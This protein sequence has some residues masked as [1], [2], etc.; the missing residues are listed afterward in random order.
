MSN[1]SSISENLYFEKI[2][3][4]VCNTSENLIKLNFH[5]QDDD[6]FDKIKIDI[7]LPQVSLCQCL[8]CSHHFANP[9]L[10]NIILDKYY[11]LHNSTL[12]N[13]DRISNAEKYVLR[14]QK[15]VKK[16]ETL[17]KG[18]KI[19]EIGC[20][21]GHLLARFD[22]QKWDCHGVEPSFIAANFA[23]ENSG[24]EIVNDFLN[25]KTY[26]IKFDVV[27]L[28]DVLEHLKNPIELMRLIYNYLE[29]NGIVVLSTGDIDSCAYQVSKYYWSYFGSWEHISFFSEKSILHLLN[30][31]RFKN[32]DISH[33]SLVNSF[34]KTGIKNLLISIIGLCF[35]K[36]TFML[37]ILPRKNKNK[38]IYYTFGKDHLI[39][40]GSK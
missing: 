35:N 8:K 14:N 10:T 36:S 15:I 23:K 11:S 7:N 4:P 3:C 17:K 26:K 32:L 28:I 18:G 34:S 40:I 33:V 22:K 31:S 13:I 1:L 29:D 6:V 38:K 2:D 30:E 9:Q 24:A 20:G 27:I 19:L 12:Y 39:A 5:Y 16:I 37:K 25:E 21:L